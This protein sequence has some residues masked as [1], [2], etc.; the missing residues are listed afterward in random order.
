VAATKGG[1]DARTLR[2][3]MVAG[4]DDKGTRLDAF[5][6]AKLS[7]Q[8][9]SRSKVQNYIKQGLVRV[10]GDVQKTPK[11]KLCAG[12]R[13]QLAADPPQEG[14][15]G[16]PGEVHVVHRDEHLLVVDKPAGLTVHPAPGEHAPTLV[17]HLV[18]SF[19][20]LAALDNERPGIVHRID[21]DTSGLL[22]VALTEKTRLALSK[23]FAAREV[24]K[25]YLAVCFGAP[26][27][28]SGRIDV[29]MGRDASNRTKMAVVERGGREA[30]SEYET[31][32]TCPDGRFSLLA[33]KI[34]TGRTH[35]IRVHLA[36]LGHP[37]AGD[38]TYGP[39]ENK[40]WAREFGGGEPP[41]SRQMLHAWRLSFA[42]PADGEA[43]RFGLRPPADFMAVLERL[44]HRPL[45][46]GVVGSPGS[47]KSALTKIL[48][49][50]GV[51]VFSADAAVA[52]LYAPGADG[53]T[54]L[55]GRFGGRFNDASGAVDKRLLFHAMVEDESVR[56]E[57]LDI[58]HP[59]VKHRLR[60]FWREHEREPLAVAEV[61]LLF[62]A[63]WGGEELADMTVCV[64]APEE[65]RHER[66]DIA[67]TWGPETAARIESWQWPQDKKIAA[68]DLV[69]D[70]SGDLGH[71]EREAEKLLERLE[72]EIES[73]RRARLDFLERLT[74]PDAE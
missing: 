68:C 7:E 24:H 60:E 45:R 17:H 25:T 22:T 44:A 23:M 73:R 28:A 74:G 27:P 3:D 10:D 26:K 62:E 72:A 37:L 57:V 53:A 41:A 64:A 48:A 1:D 11:C 69:V 16:V 52:G 4:D 59:L 21:K 58:V 66:M 14:L 5:V 32:W 43:L 39:R 49:A 51:P 31:L 40:E 56:R 30:V 46:L 34:F 42:H 67:R 2:L 38:L 18:H 20:E 71:L 65:K 63:G 50:R 36:H 70:N 54:L 29:P 9:V 55:A 61:P 47:G 6:A 13:V 35:Q 8:G 12:Q 15:E 19:P 33:V